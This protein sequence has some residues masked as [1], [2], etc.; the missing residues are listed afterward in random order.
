MLYFKEQ[1]IV[2]IYKG[3]YLLWEDIKSCFGRGFWLNQYSWD[4]K[5]GWKNM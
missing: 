2:A 1:V 4:N 3:T 5:D